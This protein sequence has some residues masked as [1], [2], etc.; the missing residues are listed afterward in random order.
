MTEREVVITGHVP[1]GREKFYLDVPFEVPAGVSR[2]DIR[3]SYSDQIGSDPHLTGG[4]TVDIGLFDWRGSDFLRGGFRG[5]TGSARDRLY[6]TPHE[7]TPGYLPGPLTAGVWHIPLGF[8]KVGPRGCDYEIVIDFTFGDE[9]ADAFPP[10]LRL[11]SPNAS[12]P[13]RESGWYR[14]ELHCHTVH[15]DGDSTAAEVIQAATAL[16]L[17]FLAIMDHNNITH[18]VELAALGPQPL[19][20]IPGYEVTTYKGH[21]NIWAPDEWIDF[22]VQAPDDM[23]RAI[24]RGIDG[25]ALTSCNHPRPFGPPW[26]YEGI[27]LSRC[28]EVWNGPWR[29]ANNVSLRFWEDRLRQGQRR[30]AVGGSDMHR[31]KSEHIAHLGIPTTWIYCSGEPTAAGL[32]DGLR[33]GHAFISEAPDGPQLYLASGATMMGDTIP[34]PPDGRLRVQ[35][36]AVGAAGCVL[37]LWGSD[38]L[39]HGATID[40]D[41]VTIEATLDAGNALYVRAQLVA[42]DDADLVRALTNP[43]YVG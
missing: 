40:A 24:Q 34:R 28:V 15:S 43:L 35:A 41:D 37:Q 4:N 32:L 1:P 38:G 27:N 3:Y 30:V 18:L 6:L 22:R 7:A 5:W 33:A 42:G 10:M 21:W 25:G 8:Y 2:I 17:D 19:I 23:R 9:R 20:L 36:R 12:L 11:D 13:A 14:G 26:E 31:L 16:G 39:L 29:L